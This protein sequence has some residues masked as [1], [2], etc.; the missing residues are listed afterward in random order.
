MEFL[1]LSN[2]KVLRLSLSLQAPSFLPAIPT[3]LGWPWAESSPLV[4]I[5]SGFALSVVVADYVRPD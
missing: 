2:L 5:K 3:C 1:V 4:G